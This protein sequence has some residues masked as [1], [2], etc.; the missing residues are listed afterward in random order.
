MTETVELRAAIRLPSMVRLGAKRV[1]LQRIGLLRRFMNRAGTFVSR[2]AAD[3]FVRR[4]THADV[5]T[6]QSNGCWTDL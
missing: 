2:R 1:P 6:G 5:L 3:R 4:R